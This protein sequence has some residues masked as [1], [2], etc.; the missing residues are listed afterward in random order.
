[1]YVHL[2]GREGRLREQPLRSIPAIVDCVADAMAPWLDRPFALFGHSIGGLV[3]FEV[4]RALRAR[5]L[6]A[7]VALFV[8]ATRPPHVP[9]P[10]P[11][12]AD[13]PVAELLRQI[14]ARYDGSVPLPVLE[15]AELQ[16]LLIPALRADLAA[17]ETYAHVQQPPLDCPISVFGGRQDGAVSPLSLDGWAAHT[18]THF[19]TRLVDGGHLY[20]QSALTTLT[21]AI[22]DDLA[23]CVALQ[24]A[25]SGRA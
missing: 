7:P 2:P 24:P 14:N 15:S 23:A 6:P 19:C 5:G 22:R 10:F 13:L 3:V 20:L 12:L 4:A 25:V 18:R 16:E 11:P 8:S 17:L 1:M 21:D 9:H